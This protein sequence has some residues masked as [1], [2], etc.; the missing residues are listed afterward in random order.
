[1]DEDKLSDIRSQHESNKEAI[2]RDFSIEFG[3][4]IKLVLKHN[5]TTTDEMLAVCRFVERY[6]NECAN[7]GKDI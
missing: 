2:Q 7:I 6:K 4:T 5:N 1:M 3:K